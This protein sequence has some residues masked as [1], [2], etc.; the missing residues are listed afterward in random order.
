[1]ACCLYDLG[2]GAQR[3]AWELR[4]CR[5]VNAW[6]ALYAAHE[7]PQLSGQGC[8]LCVA[9]WPACTIA[10]SDIAASYLLCGCMQLHSSDSSCGQDSDSSHALSAP[11]MPMLLLQ[12]EA[13]PPQAGVGE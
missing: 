1:M 7:G 12:A 9:H 10:L 2:C 13:Q 3:W 11:E 8:C 4:L 6:A 5:C